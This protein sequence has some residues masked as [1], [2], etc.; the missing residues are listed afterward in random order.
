MVLGRRFGVE[1]HLGEAVAEGVA[2]EAEE[3]GGLALIAI[4][5][6]ESFANQLLFVFVKCQAGR[7]ETVRGRRGRGGGLREC[8]E[9][10]VIWRMAPL[11]SGSFISG[12]DS[13]VF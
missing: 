6:P 12:H 2:G 1:A 9:T 3:A 5:A 4:G 8:V 13:E 10:D 7:Q 11:P